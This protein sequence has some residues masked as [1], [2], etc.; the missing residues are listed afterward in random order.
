MTDRIDEHADAGGRDERDERDERELDQLQAKL[1]MFAHDAPLRDLPARPPAIRRRWPMAALG[2]AVAAA[3]V[4]FVWLGT[5]HHPPTG[6]AG[7][8]APSPCTGSTGFAFS[9]AEGSATCGGGTV[10][11]TGTLPVG[12]WLETHANAV[13]DM[14]VADIGELRVFGD[15]KLRVVA[16]NSATQHL[17]LARGHVRASVSAPPRLFVVDTPAATAVDLG[18]QYDLTVDD[19]GTTHLRVAMGA[20]SLED[21]RG[22]VYVPATFEVSMSPGHLGT[23]VSIDS[24]PALRAAVA[25]FDTDGSIEP[26]LS[27]AEMSERVTLWNAIP[28]TTGASR[29]ALVAKLEQF[30]PLPDPALH[31]KVLAADTDAMD[32]WLDVFVDR[33]DLAHDK[34]R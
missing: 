17:E 31:D 4:A 25:R 21:K 34:R 13:A 3:A 10:A 28:R 6:T 19:Q 9:L 18:C 29:A 27:I 22:V 23:P 8:T 30:A 7:G 26:L 24:T 2:S 1:A 32:I 16:T 20:V 5:H 33:G 12:P 15:S 11:S 14:K